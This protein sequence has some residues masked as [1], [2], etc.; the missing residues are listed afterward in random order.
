MVTGDWS[1]AAEHGQASEAIGVDDDTEFG[2]FEDLEMGQK[3]DSHNACDDLQEE[4]ATKIEE[5]RLKKLSCALNLYL[6]GTL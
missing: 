4:D 5:R 6:R 1:K 3:Y 2:E